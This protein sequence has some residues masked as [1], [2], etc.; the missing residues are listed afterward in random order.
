MAISREPK[1]LPSG[2]DYVPPGGTRHKVGNNESWWTLASLPVVQSSGLS[3]SDLCFYN[4][5][6][7]NPPE[8]NW[9]LRHKV[10]CTKNT[11]D[12]KNYIFSAADSPGIVYL[13]SPGPP[14]PVHELVPSRGR[15]VN[16]WFGL[17]GKMGTQFAV[18]GIETATGPLISLDDPSKVMV[19]TV[20][21]NRLGPGWGASGG[22]AGI[23]VTGVGSPSQLNGHQEGDW[24]FNLALG[25]N[26]GK[27]AKAASKSARLKPLVDAALKIGARTPGGVKKALQTRPDKYAELVKACRSF[28]EALGI[29]PNSGPKALVFD[30]PLGGGGVEA[31]VYFGVS[32][33]TAVWDNG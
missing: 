2:L 17:I 8:V 28:N 11:R 25:P 10:G 22:V 6:T 7:R 15:R 5:R 19:V 33:F 23:Y 27:A 31:S 12:G 29:D 13:P 16:S 26:W 18:V 1:P 21:I 24:D 20:S 3:A 32:N 9:Y 4:F 30:L 14:P